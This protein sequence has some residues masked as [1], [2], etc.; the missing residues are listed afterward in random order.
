MTYAEA[1][2]ARAVLQY[3]AERRDHDIF[4]WLAVVDDTLRNFLPADSKLLAR[5][6]KV[7]AQA[8]PEGTGRLTTL[9]PERSMKIEQECKG[10]VRAARDLVTTLSEP[11][12]PL[13]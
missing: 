6:T 1:Q 12:P 8:D 13:N 11:E 10:I 9:V 7:K 5:F 4:D 3:L 2:K